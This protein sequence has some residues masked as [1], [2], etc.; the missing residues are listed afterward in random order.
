MNR[1]RYER[2]GKFEKTQIAEKIVHLIN[3]SY[4][5]FLKKEAGGWIEATNAEARNKI[6]HCFRRL[7]EIDSIRDSKASK[8]A[9]PG[10][11][12]SSE[13]SNTGSKA[14]DSVVPTENGGTKRAKSFSSSNSDLEEG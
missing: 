10:T 1:K 11:S 4:G 2:A 8:R 5:R 13:P 3:E 6:S 7:R 12:S 9:D 14:A